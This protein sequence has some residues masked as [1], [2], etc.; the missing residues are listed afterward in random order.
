MIERERERETMIERESLVN[1]THFDRRYSTPS[2]HLVEVSVRES[3]LESG[4]EVELTLEYSLELGNG[5]SI[6][7]GPKDRVFLPLYLKQQNR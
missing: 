7:W 4:Q 2:G 6:R 3:T 5:E 1:E